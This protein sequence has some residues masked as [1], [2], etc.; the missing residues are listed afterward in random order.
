MTDTVS[1]KVYASREENRNLIIQELKKYLELAKDRLELF[2]LPAYSPDLNAIE[3]LWKKTRRNVTHNK[4]FKD[5]T[6]MKQE[7][8]SYWEQFSNPNEELSRL[9]AFI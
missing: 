9:S 3:M 8:V 2:F 6:E 7:L 4:Y 5:I 1:Q